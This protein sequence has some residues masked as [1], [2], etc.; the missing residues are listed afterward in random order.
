MGKI[1][2]L[3]ARPCRCAKANDLYY[4]AGIKNYCCSIYGRKLNT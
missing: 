3:Y 2:S 1:L 4:F